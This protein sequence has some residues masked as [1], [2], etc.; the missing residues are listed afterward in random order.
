[1]NK[2]PYIMFDFPTQDYAMRYCTDNGLELGCIYFIIEQPDENNVFI[3]ISDDK[4]T[5]VGKTFF[6]QHF[7]I[8][9]RSINLEK[10]I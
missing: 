9:L 8:D 2:T 7:K 10:L 1:M 3:R 5:L 6:K 4:N